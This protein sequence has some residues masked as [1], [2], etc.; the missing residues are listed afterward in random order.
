M[1]TIQ[2]RCHAT[3]EMM[4]RCKK[5]LRESFLFSIEGRRGEGMGKNEVVVGT[6][7]GW[8]VRETDVR[9]LVQLAELL[10]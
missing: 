7:G 6:R 10:P 8:K 2:K 9:H 4:G 3:S 5:L 1:R